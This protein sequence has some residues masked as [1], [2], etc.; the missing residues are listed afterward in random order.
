MSQTAA[1][2]FL[3]SWKPGPLMP[4]GDARDGG[5]VFVIAVL[6]FFACVT[7]LAALAA[8]RAAGGWTAQLRDS[9]TVLVRA[10]NGETADA[11]AARA[12]I[13]ART[14]SLIHRLWSSTTAST[15]LASS[16]C[17]NA[18]TVAG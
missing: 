13:P 17:L 8:D 16:A 12:H 2:A 11:A 9:A 6:C 14:M 15:S 18:D 10:Q 4:R 1:D 5:L 7:A 3:K